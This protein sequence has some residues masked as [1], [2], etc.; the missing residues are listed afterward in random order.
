MALDPRDAHLLEQASGLFGELA[1]MVI[2]HY[3]KLLDA[4]IPE[5]QAADMAVDL[6]RRMLEE[7]V[8]AVDS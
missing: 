4:G 6:H 5:Q 2:R 8:E 1:D 7:Q 3:R